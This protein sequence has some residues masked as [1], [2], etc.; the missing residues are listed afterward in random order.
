MGVAPCTPCRCSFLCALSYRVWRVKLTPNVPPSLP[1][2]PVPRPPARGNQAK[3][4]SRVV[5]ATATSALL[6]KLVSFPE[7]ES[8]SI[9]QPRRT[10]AIVPPTR[11]K[12]ASKNREPTAAH[13]AAS[14]QNDPTTESTLQPQL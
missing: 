13:R 1:K 12:P 5:V 3:A 2:N 6:R 11:K 14:R 10:R 4:I 8:R 7:G 9:L